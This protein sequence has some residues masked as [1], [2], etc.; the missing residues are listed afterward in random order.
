MVH[1]KYED[2]INKSLQLCILILALTILAAESSSGTG[3]NIRRKFL[4][5][6]FILAII[7]IFYGL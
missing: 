5:A 2:N 7:F 4:P 1:Q 3:N 6:V